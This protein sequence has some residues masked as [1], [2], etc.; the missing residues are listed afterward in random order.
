MPLGFAASC[1]MTLQH[2]PMF[3]D[4][5]FV[6]YAEDVNPRVVV[7]AWPVLETVKN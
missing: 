1:G 5:A 3:N 4:F 7:V 2:L 6:I